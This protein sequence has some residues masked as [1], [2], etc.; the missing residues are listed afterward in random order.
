[1]TG[2]HI[3]AADLALRDEDLYLLDE[4]RKPWERYRKDIPRKHVCCEQL[5]GHL[6]ADVYV[7][8]DAEKNFIYLLTRNPSVDGFSYCPFC[9]H[10]L[11]QGTDEM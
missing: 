9:G 7:R 8:Y 10:E 5:Y 3:N 11:N 2:Y 4:D 1:M 6:C